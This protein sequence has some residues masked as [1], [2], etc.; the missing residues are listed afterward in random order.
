MKTLGH[1]REEFKKLEKPYGRISSVENDCIGQSGLEIQ[2]SPSEMHCSLHS[3]RENS[4][5]V[6]TEAQR[7][8]HCCSNSKQKEQRASTKAGLEL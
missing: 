6:D 7:D 2:Q 4:S 5:A 8:P 1:Q 3:G